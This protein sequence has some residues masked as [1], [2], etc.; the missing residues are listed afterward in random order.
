[1]GLNKFDRIEG[2]FFSLIVIGV[3]LFV[4][5]LIYRC[6]MWVCLCI[7]GVYNTP[8]F[9]LVWV[10]RATFLLIKFVL[11]L[12]FFLLIVRNVNSVELAF[13]YVLKCHV[14]LC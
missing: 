5:F 4:W 10:N 13:L 9:I 2:I 11:Y 14:A 7:C 1:V 3:C 6:L 12:K 8:W